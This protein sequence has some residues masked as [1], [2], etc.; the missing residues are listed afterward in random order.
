M[1]ETGTLLGRYADGYLILV[2]ILA[3]ILALAIPQF[4][5]EVVTDGVDC[6]FNDRDGAANHKTAAQE[7]SDAEGDSEVHYGK[8]DCFGHRVLP[9]SYGVD[10]MR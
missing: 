6:W 10:L 1:P 4:F 8:A 7:V 2:L 5:M 3:S 9:L